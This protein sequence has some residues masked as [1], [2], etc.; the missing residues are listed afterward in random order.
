ML[1][2]LVAAFAITATHHYIAGNFLAEER[3]I[4]ALANFNNCARPFVTKSHWKFCLAI[5]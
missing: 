1:A 5:M 4:Y 3:F 2:A